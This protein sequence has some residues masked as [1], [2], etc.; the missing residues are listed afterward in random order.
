MRCKPFSLLGKYRFFRDTSNCDFFSSHMLFSV[1]QKLLHF[2]IPNAENVI[3]WLKAII[4]YRFVTTSKIHII[5]RINYLKQNFDLIS[6]D[7]VDSITTQSLV[8]F[9]AVIFLYLWS[10]DSDL[11]LCCLSLFSLNS[12]HSSQISA[13]LHSPLSYH[14]SS[15]TN[16]ITAGRVA[17]QKSLYKNLRTLPQSNAALNEVQI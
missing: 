3:T 8:K 2:Q 12:I 5:F 13:T 4:Q 14:L 15:A 7:L 10:C 1:C 17:L 6:E 9:E 16:I 11:V